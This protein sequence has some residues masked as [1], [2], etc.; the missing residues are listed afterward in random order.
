ML[1]VWFLSD[2]DHRR[3]IFIIRVRLFHSDLIAHHRLQHLSAV[4]TGGY[5]GCC[6]SSFCVTSS[7]SRG[8]WRSSSAKWS[9]NLSTGSIRARS[10]KTR[11]RRNRWEGKG[12][13]RGGTRQLLQVGDITVARGCLFWCSTRSR[14]VE[15]A[16][17]EETFQPV[18]GFSLS[19]FPAT[20]RFCW[21]RR[22][23]SVRTSYF[24]RAWNKTPGFLCN[25][26]TYWLEGKKI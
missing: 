14:S 8:S 20:L 23:R 19:F 13:R 21:S 5:Q 11:T 24:T 4:T 2:S 7:L 22:L 25:N 15:H 1:K 10:E 18:R 17:Q 12:G 16:G 3:I 26:A 9:R 6:G